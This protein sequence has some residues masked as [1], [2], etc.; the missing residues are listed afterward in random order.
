LAALSFLT[1]EFDRTQHAANAFAS[2]VTV[3]DSGTPGIDLVF[4]TIG[5]V[6]VEFMGSYAPRRI[7]RRATRRRI[8]CADA[9]RSAH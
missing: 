9:T 4:C 5:G 7:Q 6:P 1:D 3:F 8:E 2:D